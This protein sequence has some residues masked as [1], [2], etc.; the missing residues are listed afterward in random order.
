MKYANMLDDVTL[1]DIMYEA[2]TRLGGAMMELWR[3][4]DSKGNVD[5]RDKWLKERQDLELKR[6]AIN[7]RDRNAQE[8]AYD[9]WTKRT[10]N[11][12][13]MIDRSNADVKAA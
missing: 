7:P 12:Y 6:R 4:A 11:L 3:I 5:E 10:E 13:A 1:Y 8:L 2:G 9:D